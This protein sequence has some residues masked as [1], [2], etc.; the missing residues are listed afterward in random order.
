MKNFGF[1][2]YLSVKRDEKGRQMKTNI[3][4]PLVHIF[5]QFS[6]TK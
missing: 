1:L 6:E 4:Y 3:V 5:K 2:I